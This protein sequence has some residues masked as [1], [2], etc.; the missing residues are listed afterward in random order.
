MKRTFFVAI[1]ALFSL[2]LSAQQL[3]VGTYN[4]RYHNADDNKN[5]N[6][7]SVRSKVLC[8][9][10]NF[11]DP[12]IF[13]CQE[14]LDAQ[15]HDMLALLDGYSYVGVGRDDGKTAGEY[16]PIFYKKDRLR[17]L[18]SGNF[19]LN[20]TPNEPKKGWDAACIRICSWGEFELMG[21]SLRFF[22]FNLH[23]DHIGIIARRE[24]AKLVVRKIK[25]IAQGQPVVLTGDFNVD[26]TDE[27]YTLFTASDL[28]RDAYECARL[29]F[30]E[31]GTYNS[32]DPAMYTTS[33]IDH[34]FVSPSFAV[35]RYGVLTNSY[36]TALEQPTASVKSGDAPQEISVK[37]HVQR[38]PSDHYPVFVK[39][40]YAPSATAAKHTTTKQSEDS[41]I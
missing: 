7:W 40:R 3:F 36:W 30:A 21:T 6:E 39:M 10:V 18:Q 38:T 15:L 8:D 5:G 37:Q 14:V 31:N 1:A 19:W 32:F 22:Y 13:G 24:G 4:I 27:I 26:Q 17:L 41:E 29:R 16:S 20:E 25:E 9:Q 2:S 23:M 33:R 34:V 12:D 28:L 11:E 35:D